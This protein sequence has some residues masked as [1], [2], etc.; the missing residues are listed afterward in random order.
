MGDRRW[1]RA[2]R[3]LGAGALAVLLPSVVVVVL[4]SAVGVPDASAVYL[5]GVTVMAIAF[6]VPGGVLCAVASVLV[7][8]FLFTEPLYTLTVSD[9]GEWLNLVLLLFVGVTVGELAGLQRRRAES[10]AASERESR[11][12]FE[13]TRALATRTTTIDALPSMARALARDARMD[14][15]WFALE[16]PDAERPVAQS[17]EDAAAGPIRAYAA[18]HRGRDGSPDT[19]A[20]VRAPLPPGGPATGVRH[21]RVRLEDAGQPIGSIWAT[22]PRDGDPPD[23][24]T[25]TLLRVAADLVAQ[26]VAH[27]RLAEEAGRAEVA[28]QSDAVKSALLQSVSHDLRTPLAS[29]RA[30]AGTLMDPEIALESAEARASAAAIDR[31]A[32]RLN[33]LVGNLLDLSRIDGGVLRAA[34]EALDLE[35]VVEAAVG[36][37]Q[38]GSG[39]RRI[40]TSI[41]EG[42]AVQADPALIEQVL[43]NLLDNA[44]RHTPADATIRVSAVVGNGRVVVTVEDSG[45]GVPRGALA[46]I[47]DKFYR[48]GG[49]TRGSGAGTGIGLAVVLGFVEAMGGRASARQS[50]LGGLAVDVDLRAAELPAVPAMA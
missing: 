14:A 22:R 1:I 5:I 4:E 3:L 15:V 30:F 20:Q 33:R 37:V 35:D 43:V 9:P 32:Q 48:A 47:F 11:A 39:D 23:P 19:W 21:Y 28:R 13:V 46:R 18:L 50:E 36:H 44:Q 12:L 45:P 40:E 26:A 17:G 8:D 49:A 24:P 29:I 25:M 7:Y 16:G 6:G 31:E 41:P 42:A 34:D 38:V 27:D 2:G 10:A